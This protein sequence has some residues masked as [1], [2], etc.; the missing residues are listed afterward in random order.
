MNHIEERIDDGGGCIEAWQAASES[1]DTGISTNTRRTF[2]GLIGGLIFGGATSSVASADAVQELQTDTDVDLENPETEVEELDDREATNVLLEILDDNEQV[3]Q[4]LDELNARDYVIDAKST[5]ARRS[6]FN[7]ESWVVLSIPFE[8]STFTTKPSLPGPDPAGGLYENAG[9]IVDTRAE[10]NPIGFVSTVERPAKLKTS[11]RDEIQYRDEIDSFVE[12]IEI[13]RRHMEP[14]VLKVDRLTVQDG[15]VTPETNSLTIPKAKDDWLKQA[16]RAQGG[17][18]CWAHIQYTA[19][20]PCGPPKL[21]CIA[22][23]ARNYA[24]EIAACGTCIASSG[25]L[26]AACGICVAAV[27]DGEGLSGLCCPCGTWVW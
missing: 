4:L 9:I 22:S 24:T 2:M 26:T 12:E 3:N 21:G 19:C 13:P 18:G 10:T 17:C 5:T 25:W 6:T 16:P 15:N 8:G 27:I 7:G 20:Q 1:R 23:M 14:V 11:S